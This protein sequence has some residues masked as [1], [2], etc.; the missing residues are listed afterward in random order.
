M[1]K[2]TA[3]ISLL[4]ALVACST[5]GPVQELANGD[6]VRELRAQQTFDPQASARN[7]T[8]TPLG[9]D[10]DVADTAIKNMRS[11]TGSRSTDVKTMLQSMFGGAAGTR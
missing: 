10:P 6:A 5:S 9:T 3:L 4:A 7:G 2:Q 11:S 1:I 8:T